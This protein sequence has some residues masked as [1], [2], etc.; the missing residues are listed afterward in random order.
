[1]TK[2]KWNRA[3]H[4]RPKF[5]VA[6]ATVSE[7]EQAHV[8]ASS[9]DMSISAMLR[10]LLKDQYYRLAKGEYIPSPEQSLDLSEVEQ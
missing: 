7:W 2:G 6:C 5:L 4:P 3:S 8:I 10:Q 1:M 9:M